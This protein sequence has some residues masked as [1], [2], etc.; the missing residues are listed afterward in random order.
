MVT[1][2]IGPVALGPAQTP[3]PMFS[4]GS[5]GGLSVPTPAYGEPSSYVGRLADLRGPR[6]P[7]VLV[8]T[9]VVADVTEVWLDGDTRW[10][11]VAHSFHDGR[12]CVFVLNRTWLP[13]RCV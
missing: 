12:R 1:G 3:R 5:A 7:K 6:W 10:R 13:R 4:S 2:S 11:V 8:P 9:H